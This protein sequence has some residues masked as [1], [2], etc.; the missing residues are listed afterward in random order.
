MF[1]GA[2]IAGEGF[3]EEGKAYERESG[4]RKAGHGAKDLVKGAVSHLLRM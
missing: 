4:R 2:D 1:L 3:W